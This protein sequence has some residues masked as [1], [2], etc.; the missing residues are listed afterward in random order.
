M[1]LSSTEAAAGPTLLQLENAVPG[2][3]PLAGAALIIIDAQEEYRKGALP[4]TGVDAALTQAAALLA[5]SRA[6]GGTVIHIVHKGSEGT[7][8]DPAGFGAIMQEVAPREGEAVI[9]KT[10]PSAFAGTG[11]A[12]QLRAAGVSQIVLAG[13]MTHVCVSSTARAGSELGFTVTVAGDATATRPLPHPLTGETVSAA[14]LQAAALT[15]ISDVFAGVVTTA[16]ILAG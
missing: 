6:A 11:L 3:P 13:F 2:I 7:V 10:E 8:F 16:A 1:T 14:T 15:A 4:L 5:A 12:D 9:G